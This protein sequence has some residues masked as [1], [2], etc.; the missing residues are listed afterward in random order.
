MNR[1]TSKI[2]K[3][4]FSLRVLI[5]VIALIAAIYL[6]YTYITVD[7]IMLN[8]NDYFNRLWNDPTVN[9]ALLFFL[10]MP[11]VV[12]Y[13]LS[14]YWLQKLL[15]HYQNGVFFGQQPM[16]CYLWLVWLNV[17]TFL[18]SILEHI[19]EAYYYSTYYGDV[20]LDLPI[21]IANINTMILLLIIT[22]LLKAAKEIDSENKEFI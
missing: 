6:I 10:K 7:K 12:A 15:S 19:S 3:I 14:I 11:L 4:S 13:I 18:I 5:I 9:H 21:N 8:S 20:E 17:A 1:N 16:R 2:K 22:Y